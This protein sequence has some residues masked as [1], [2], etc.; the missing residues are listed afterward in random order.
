MFATMTLLLRNL[1]CLCR[2]STP[3]VWFKYRSRVVCT[4]F[5]FRVSKYCLSLYPPMANPH[6]TLKQ[7]DTLLLS[8]RR[9]VYRC[10]VRYMRMAAWIRVTDASR[11]SRRAVAL[12]SQMYLTPRWIVVA[13]CVAGST[14]RKRFGD[15]RR[16]FYRGI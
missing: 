3:G 14:T 13:P 5:F 15:S 1:G 4:F 7:A 11:R 16:R 8:D 2:K 12:L 6:V 9:R 10:L